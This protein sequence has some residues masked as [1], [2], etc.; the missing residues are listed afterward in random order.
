MELAM[1]P[2]EPGGGVGLGKADDEP[3]CGH[4]DDR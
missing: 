1:P 2:L 3:G 4:L